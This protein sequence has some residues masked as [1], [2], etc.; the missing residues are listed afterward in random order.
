MTLVRRTYAI[1]DDDHQRSSEAARREG[2]QSTV[3]SDVPR[4][5]LKKDSLSVESSKVVHSPSIPR[6][7][8]NAFTNGRREWLNTV[9]RVFLLIGWTVRRPTS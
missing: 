8:R 3:L 2:V 7:A 9:V 4:S 1:L 5:M 6:F